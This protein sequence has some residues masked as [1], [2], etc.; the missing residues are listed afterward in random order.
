VEQGSFFENMDTTE[1][2][3]IMKKYIKEYMEN[4]SFPGFEKKITAS[5]CSIRVGKVE[6]ATLS[7]DFLSKRC[8]EPGGIFGIQA[9]A[10][11]NGGAIAEIVDKMELSYLQ[12]QNYPIYPMV[13]S[14]CSE[15]DKIP[16][17]KRFARKN[18]TLTIYQDDNLAE[19]CEYIVQK[20]N[21][22]YVPRIVNF[23]L[24]NM[25]V[26]EDIFP[27][28]G[29]YRYPMA[30]IITAC[31]LNGKE[32]TAVE[33]IKLARTKKINHS[34]AKQVDEVL[35]KIQYLHKY[36]SGKALV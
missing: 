21:T 12:H 28:Q 25:E 22:L 13:I 2:K 18:G 10:V 16:L 6:I 34:S 1:I 32:E 33:M 31:Y 9:Q 36:R 26:I 5:G 4:L 19:K 3:K 27:S 14:S 20:L 17:D 35:G 8:A 24:G 30:A 7:I 23:A 11:V 15:T 29:D